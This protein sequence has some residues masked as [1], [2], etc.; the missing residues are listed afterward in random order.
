MHQNIL[1]QYW[2][3]FYRS[4]F[5]EAKRQKQT[6]NGQGNT[7]VAEFRQIRQDIDAGK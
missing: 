2:T 3:G 4:I 7:P 6:N 1:S 5:S